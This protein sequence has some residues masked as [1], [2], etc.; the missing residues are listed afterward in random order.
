VLPD[1][2]EALENLQTALPRIQRGTSRK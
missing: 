1:V 2:V